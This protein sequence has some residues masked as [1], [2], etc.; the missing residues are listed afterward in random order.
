MTWAYQQDS[1][2]SS[3]PNSNKG[4]RKMY[5]RILSAT[6]QCVDA[7]SAIRSGGPA[8]TAIQQAGTGL[9]LL[10]LESTNIT[11]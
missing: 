9:L 1:A 3:F 5:N 8:V 7:I 11:G 2:L 10:C 4:E 6:E